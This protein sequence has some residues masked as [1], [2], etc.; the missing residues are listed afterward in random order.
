TETALKYFVEKAFDPAEPGNFD[1]VGEYAKRPG[2]TFSAY[3][4]VTESLKRIGGSIKISAEMAEDLPFIVTEINNRL[5]YQLLM[6]EEDALL[7]GTGTGSSITGILNREGLQTETSGGAQDNLDALYR[8][9]TKV[10]LATGLNAD[11]V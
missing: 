9:L 10:Q 4:D 8:A 6:F 7:N 1:Y 2:I 5:L 11:G 3:D